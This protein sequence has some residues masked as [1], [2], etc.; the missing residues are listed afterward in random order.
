M[1]E[2]QKK[3]SA[4]VNWKHPDGGF[5]F[6][7][8]IS[9]LQGMKCSKQNFEAPAEE[10]T[11]KKVFYISFHH[12]NSMF[13]S[14]KIIQQGEWQ[15]MNEQETMAYIEELKQYGSVPGLANMENLCE[16]LGH[17]EKKLK[18]VHIAGTNGKGSTLAYLSEILKE[19]GYRVGRY[20]SPTIFDYRER[21]QVN[22][23]MITKKAL[24]EG[25]TLLK[26]LCEELV[27]EGKPHPTAFEIETALGF[28]YFTEKNCDIVVLEAGLGGTLDATNIITDTLVEVFA[29]I[30]MDHMKV[31]GKTLSEIARA[32][33][34][35]MKKNSIAVTTT[36][37]EPVME[38]LRRHAKEVG[39]PLCEVQ[40]EKILKKKSTLAVQTF[41]YK[42]SE[43]FSIHLPGRYQIE[44]AALAL[45]AIEALKKQGLPVSKKA[46]RTGL[47]KAAWP[48]RFQV[49]SSKPY[50]IVDGAHNR[51]GAKRLE[52]SLEYYF[53]GKRMIFIVGVLRDK[54]REEILK[55]TSP[56]AEQILTIS[57]KGERGLSSYELAVTASKYHPQV[58]DVGGLQ[59]A[60]ELA[61][62]MADKETVIVAFGSLSYLGELIPMVERIAAQKTKKKGALWTI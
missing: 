57:T 54:E 17:P 41:C 16:K 31:L 59:E 58:T 40:Q 21:I 55:V 14:E 56:L 38:V 36:Q 52:E 34:G 43:S 6:Q 49:V 46:V 12:G 48:G 11:F 61:Y 28:W 29:S 1:E 62:L 27:A 26:D 22:G 4:S 45:E 33:A 23:R 10:T 20:I 35:I 37:D 9:S 30:S 42:Q 15:L 19:S 47:E 8:K 25:M 44:N 32:K 24:A 3:A 60:V 53:T 50:F 7:G 51:D 18:F 13:H 39:I 5:T 2:W